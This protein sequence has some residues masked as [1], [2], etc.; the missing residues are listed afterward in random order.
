MK[1]NIQADIKF[2]LECEEFTRIAPML[3]YVAAINPDATKK[4]FIEAAVE[5]NYNPT[6]AAIQFAQS[7]KFDC[8]S[9][10]HVLDKDG[11]LILQ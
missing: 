3:R 9:Y 6:T 1:T 7:R 4:E 10:G 2:A 11:R 5:L 8:D